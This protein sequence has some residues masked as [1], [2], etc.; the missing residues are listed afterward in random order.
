MKDKKRYTNTQVNQ[1]KTKKK[2]KRTMSSQFYWFLL[3][4]ASLCTFLILL[5]T[6]VFPTKWAF[7]VLALLAGV[8]LLT[9]IFTSIFSPKNKVQ[10]VINCTLAVCLG[11][12]CVLTPYYINKITDLFNSALGEKVRINLYV[13]TDEYKDAHADTFQNT[14]VLPDV[15]SNGDF[16]NVDMQNYASAVYGT[17]IATDSTN[18]QYALN[19]LKDLCGTQVQTIDRES[20]GEAV[21]SFYNNETDILIMSEALA[22]SISDI[23][24]FETFETD[25]KVLYTITRIIED[26]SASD[27]VNVNMTTK[28]FTIFFGG[29]D[30]EG[31]LSLE[32]RTDVNMAVS[33]NPNTHQIAIISLPR[34]SYIPNPEYND[35]YDKLT[36]LGMS[37]ISNTLEGLGNYL[38]EDISNYVIVNFTTFTNIVDALGGVEVNNPYAF[39]AING[40]YFG[41]GVIGM[42][43]DIA[44]L[45][46]RERQNLPDG[47]FGRNMH[48]QLVMEAII[49]KITSAEGIMKFN[50]IL[51]SLSGNFLT[52]VS[53]DSIYALVKKQLNEG[54]SWNI[55]KYSIQGETGMNACASAGGQALSVVYPY[56]NQIE[57]VRDI[58]DSI[59][60]GDILTQEE[61]P[62][63]EIT[64][65]YP[66]YYYEDTSSYDETGTDET[67]DESQTYDETYDNTTYDNTQDYN[68]DNSTD[69]STPSDDQ[70]TDYYDDPNQQTLQ[71]DEYGN[72]I[73]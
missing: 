23:Q 25:T 36:H 62:A 5:N 22:S 59:Y 60:N 55:V 38:E 73:Y 3:L 1:R 19:E 32:G 46:C 39:T 2:K 33:V 48:Q 45:Y 35:S 47:D 20:L 21:Q 58:I 8:L 17:T 71:Y 28:P 43:A 18:Q 15:D 40:S 30:M 54:I 41:E 4:I 56:D 10:K 11:L 69:W 12:V 61:L 52:N 44:L 34:D 66:T 9:G 72:P 53:S 26:T 50:D 27:A 13:L 29:N 63:G 68:Y 64:T 65:D 70:T 67:Y 51:D 7:L 16:I 6:S 24:G 57:F 37:G 31:D 49:N 42:S 14:I